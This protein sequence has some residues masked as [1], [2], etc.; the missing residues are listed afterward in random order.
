[1]PKRL[2]VIGVGPGSPKYLTEVAKDAISKSRFVIGYKS[3][4]DIIK[5]VIDRRAQKISEITMENQEIV[6]NEIYNKMTTSDY[7]TVPF[8]GDVNFSESEVV[9]RLLEIF[10]DDN[11]EVIPGISSVQIAAAKS[12][13]PIDKAHIITFHVSGDIEGKKLELL[14][15][16][17]DLKSIILLPRP[18]PSNPA[19]NFMPSEIATFLRKNGVDTSNLKVY[20]YEFLTHDDRETLFQ[21][22]VSELEGKYFDA[23]SVMVIDQV[24]RRTYLQFD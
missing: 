5:D 23:F 17:R 16:L 19:K 7:C 6:Y 1:L 21:G 18:W 8:T 4:L 20:V 12:K 3:T 15:A 24:I 10:G 11:V 22:R 9:D 14:N 13:V 2:F